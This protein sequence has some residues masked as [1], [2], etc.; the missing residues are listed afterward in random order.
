MLL[1]NTL[2]NPKIITPAL[3]A[4]SVA[5]SSDEHQPGQRRNHSQASAWISAL[6]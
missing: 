4:Q 3:L 2:E 6:N 5:L 1:V